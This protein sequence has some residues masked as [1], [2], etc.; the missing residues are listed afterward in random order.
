MSTR[1][2]GNQTF[3]PIGCKGAPGEMREI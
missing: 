2:T 3:V 1:R